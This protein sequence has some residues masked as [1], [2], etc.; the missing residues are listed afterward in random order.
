MPIHPFT[1]AGKE[2]TIK[3]IKKYTKKNGITAYMFV[4][5]LGTDPA[6][7]K[8]KRTTRRGFETYKEARIAES[9]LLASLE[10][11]KLNEG[12]YKFKD[13]NDS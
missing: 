5:Y 9:R 3:M 8:Q 10:E 12:K 6:T 1:L 7:G 13:V 2:R 11:E 4:A